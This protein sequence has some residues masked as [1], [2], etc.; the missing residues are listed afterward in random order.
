MIFTIFNS[1][2]V[3][4]PYGVWACMIFHSTFSRTRNLGKYSAAVDLAEAIGEHPGRDIC[5]YTDGEL[6]KELKKLPS[7]RY[8][9]EYRSRDAPAYIGSSSQEKGPVNFI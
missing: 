5:A 9:I 7:I 4:M 3:I 2:W 1:L 6:E 8:Y